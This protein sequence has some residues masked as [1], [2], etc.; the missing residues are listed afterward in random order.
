M[1]LGRGLSLGI[2]FERPA[3]SGPV[4][5]VV[6]TWRPD[7]PTHKTAAAGATI[8]FTPSGLEDG[9]VLLAA[10][11]FAYPGMSLVSRPWGAGSNLIDA[12]FRFVDIKEAT[13]ADNTTHVWTVSPT[14][15]SRSGIMIAL[16]NANPTPADYG[17]QTS[18]YLPVL[19]NPAAG[20]IVVGFFLTQA[21]APYTTEIITADAPL[22]RQLEHVSIGTAAYT[23]PERSC[24]AIEQDPP[25]GILNFR[26]FNPNN[27]P[28][29]RAMGVLLRPAV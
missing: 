15:Y 16:R 18:G 27:S 3:A 19:V 9:D 8:K 22:E 12:T 4:I 1:R 13:T 10:Y 26:H 29:R 11:G 28:N 25:L 24:V 6:G 23:L 14:N 7:P 20:S 5:P 17:V 21:E 2:E